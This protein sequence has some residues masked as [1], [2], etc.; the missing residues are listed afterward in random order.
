MASVAE[1]RVAWAQGHDAAMRAS[2]SRKARLEIERHVSAIVE[3]HGYA[4]VDGFWAKPRLLVHLSVGLQP[5]RSGFQC[6]VNL[7][8]RPRPFWGALLGAGISENL[9]LGSFYR[10]SERGQGEAG[11]MMYPDICAQDP[12][13]AVACAVLDQ[14]ALPFMD[15][16]TGRGRADVAAFVERCP[17]L[18][19]SK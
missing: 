10:P 11:A 5:S 7:A 4:R 3:R 18:V 19:L 15:R 9:R 6:Y 2:L 16:V 17:P 8:A 1:K 12:S 14:R 13:F